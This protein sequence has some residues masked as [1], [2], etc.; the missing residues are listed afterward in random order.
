[1]AR[2]WRGMKPA[3][4][5][6]DIELLRR[7]NPNESFESKVERSEGGRVPVSKLLE[8]FKINDSM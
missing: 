2:P 1:M 6:P 4:R 8:S 7:Y 5:V 3:G